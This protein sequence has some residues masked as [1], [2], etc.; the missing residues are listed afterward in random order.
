MREKKKPI[1]LREPDYLA[2]A[3]AKE[4]WERA[5]GGKTDWAAFLMLLLGLAKGA[6]VVPTEK[7]LQS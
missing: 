4:E 5:N 7:P 3:K 2:L 6:G 1:W